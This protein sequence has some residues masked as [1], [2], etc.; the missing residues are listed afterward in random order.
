MEISFKQ[1]LFS[2][3]PRNKRCVDCGDKNVTYV[4]VNNG[5]T[6]CELCSQIHKQLGPKISL[7]RKIDEDLDDDS[8]NYF[9]YGGNKHFK[10]TLKKL[11]VDIDMQKSKLYK[12]YGVDYYRKYL[13]S[14]VK[15]IENT[16]KKPENPNELINVQEDNNEIIE[17][18][19]NINN[20]NK[21][22]EKEKNILIDD[23]EKENNKND[24]EKKNNIKTLYNINNNIENKINVE[25]INNGESEVQLHYN[26]NGIINLDENKKINKKKSL[27][28]S[29]INKVKDIG[30]YIRKNSVK[31]L[32]AIKKA[33]NIIVQKSKP[34]A[35]KIKYT[36]KYVGNHM[37]HF[38]ISKV[39]SQENIRNTNDFYFDNNSKK[40]KIKK[41]IEDPKQIEF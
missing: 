9:I 24:E 23:E 2:I 41:Q 18:K 26:E 21:I 16:E 14:K 19:F 33:G 13:K 22:I 11:G 38:H 29:S 39:K 15:G 7:L 8:M 36:A 12:T 6:I 10:K 17:N 20:N 28:K 40:G 5:V 1:T 37:P 32:V 30:G 35:E 3:E 27:L 34:A 31:S 25:E 4:S